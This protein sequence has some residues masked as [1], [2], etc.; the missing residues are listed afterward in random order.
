MR[1]LLADLLMAAVDAML[2]DLTA[3]IAAD[4]ISGA[5]PMSYDWTV[6]LS[7]F[8][9]LWSAVVG[10]VFSAFSEFIMRALLRA[11]PAG[12]IE[13]MQHIN[14]TVLRSQFVAGIL[15]IA[16]ISV[17]I[18]VYAAGNVE[19]A[20]R[21]ALIAAPLVYVPS[22]FLMTLFGNVPMN[23]RLARLDY[24]SLEAEEY[25]QTYGRGWT[26]LNHVRT[27]GSVLTAGLYLIAAI[28]LVA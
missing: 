18:G 14:R 3:V 2:V 15:V 17:A 5:N 9:A 16:P 1:Q 26:R 28:S 10:G 21:M 7:L 12:G 11:E 19:G 4:S 20:A 23:N 25:W 27:F 24:R 6:Y 13:A 8:L 22:V